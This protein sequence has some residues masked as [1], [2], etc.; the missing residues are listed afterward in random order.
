MGNEKVYATVRD[1]ISERRR[2]A[3]RTADLHKEELYRI[4]P[5]LKD[6][7]KRLSST[8]LRLFNVNSSVEDVAAAIEKIREENLYLQ[9]MKKD[10]VISLGYPE[11]YLY[12]DYV[13]KKCAD[14]GYCDDRMCECMRRE[15]A[16]LSFL[17]SGLGSLSLKQSFDNF[18]FS[19]YGDSAD[20]MKRLVQFLKGFADRLANGN[21]GNLLLMGGTGVGKTHLTTAL[22]KS[23]IERGIDVFYESAPN[24]MNDFER[25]RFGREDAER[26]TDKYFA[27]TLLIIDDLGAEVITDYTASCLYNLINTRLNHGLVTV[28]NTNFDTEEIEERYTQRISS[29]LLGE[30]TQFAIEAEDIRQA[31]R[32]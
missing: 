19:Y 17:E 31:K 23:V 14:T 15:I 8:G 10:I 32:K 22:A 9:K 24:V 4:S 18:D 3:E 30:F 12:P 1:Q 27:V 16:R 2:N 11:N 25:E 6:I 21:A 20:T 5:E 28:I 26:R 13:C 7:D 29:R